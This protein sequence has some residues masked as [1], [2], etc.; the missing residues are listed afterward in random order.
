MNKKNKNMAYQNLKKNVDSQNKSFSC[1]FHRMTIVSVGIL[2]FSMLHM[3]HSA[4]ID[5]NIYNSDNFNAVK[6]NHNYGFAANTKSSTVSPTKSQQD[7]LKIEPLKNSVSNLK[8]RQNLF[9]DSPNPVDSQQAFGSTGAVATEETRCSNIGLE[10]L[11]EGGSAVD[12]AIASGICIGLVNGF[13]SGIGGGGFVVIRAADGSSELIDFREEAP[14]LATKDMYVANKTLS[15][16]GGLASGVPGELRGYELAHKRHGRLSWKRLLE[17]TIKLARDGYV[18]G[19]MLGYNLNRYEKNINSTEGF[20]QVYLGA[21]GKVLKEGDMAKRVNFAKTLQKIADEGVD[22]FYKGSLTESMVSSIKKAGGIITAEDFS[23]YKAKLRK[24]SVFEYNGRKIIA[25]T[26][27]TSG[28]IVGFIYNVIEGY[29]FKDKSNMPTNIHRFV[30]TLK[31]AYSQR[32]RIADP[33]YENVTETLS[34][35]Q[36]KEFAAAIRKNI[37]DDVTHPMTIVSVGILAFSMLHMG[38][39]AYIDSN[40]YNSD[41]FNAVKLN[42]NYGFAANTKSSTVSPTKSQQDSLKIE[43]LKN[44][45]SN[46][47]VR[48]NLFPDSPNPVDS[49]QAFG[50]TG[51]V[52]T[53]ETRC[54]NIGLEILKEGGSAVDAAIASGICIGLVNGFSSGIGGGGFVVIRAADGSSELID[55]RE[56]APALATKDMYVANKT[57]S[58][59]GGLASGVP[60]ELRG[61][62]LAHK[63]HG[64]L[65]WKRLL[66]PTIKLARDGYVVGKMLGY[67]LNRYEKNINSTEGFKQVYLGANGKVLKEGDMAKRVNFA[68][69]LQKIADEGVDAFYK[70]SLTESMVSSIKKAGGIIT[71]EDF[72]NYKAKLRKTSVFEYNGRKIIAGTPPTSGSIVGFIYNV[73]EGYNFK[74]KSNMPTNIHRFVE[75]LK[76]AYSQRTRIADPDYEN[77]TETLSNQQSKEFAAA[78]R[79]NIT[80]DVTHPFEYYDP[81]YDIEDNGTTHISVLDK[82]GMAVSLTSTINTIFGAKVMDPVTGVMFNN[83]MDGFSTPGSANNYGLLPSPKGYIKPGKRPLSSTSALVVEYCGKPEIVLGASGGSRIITAT[84]QVLLNMLEFDKNLKE[85]IDYPRMH[86]QLL[87]N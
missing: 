70:G 27:P 28:S 36:S 14:A 46:L 75:T 13:S 22:A 56:E 50:S 17:P 77:V 39:S 30:E 43:P 20:K 57:L 25:G 74:D 84:A 23:N 48:Q 86:H 58:T 64:R 65:S 26:P 69:T 62:E 76:F 71:A 67:N 11:K 83:E 47:K 55:F 34:N 85:A 53:E 3:G 33:D 6:L 12:A 44:S 72:S 80:D 61:Y 52:A 66:E 21:N 10:I 63:R 15:T 1:F 82:N 68:K 38:H 29:N 16:L 35:Q 2:A 18:V 31:F 7:S 78:I 19:K 32:T 49:Q 59:L 73:I 45:V 51:A 79:K 54:S 24:T 9:P 81:E 5:S 37:T 87:P 40:I 42:H 41:N 8:V 60:G 4:Y